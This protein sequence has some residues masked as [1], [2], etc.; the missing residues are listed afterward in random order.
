MVAE[1]INFLLLKMGVFGIFRFGSQDGQV[2]AEKHGSS[3][4]ETPSSLE[5]KWQNQKS[6]NV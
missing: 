1:I 2:P 5:K 4:L 3:A 6:G